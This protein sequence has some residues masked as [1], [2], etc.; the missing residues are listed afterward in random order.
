MSYAV[1]WLCYVCASSTGTLHNVN[2]C[3]YLPEGLDFKANN[4]R[5]YKRFRVFVVENC[6]P[7]VVVD[8]ETFHVVRLEGVAQRETWNT[9]N[10]CYKVTLHP[11]PSKPRLFTFVIML[12]VPFI[13]VLDI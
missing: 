7:V 11:T 4:S 6:N 1:V 12:G 3:L 5:S 2:K 10:Q 9:H 8:V 13:S